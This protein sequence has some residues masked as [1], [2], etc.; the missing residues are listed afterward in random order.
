MCIPAPRRG[1]CRHW[2]IHRPSRSLPTCLTVLWHPRYHAVRKPFQRNKQEPFMDMQ[3]KGKVVLITG[4]SQGIGAGLA[5]AFAEEGCTLI[6]VAR[7]ADKL[8]D[9]A[10]RLKT[11]FQADTR[12][13]AVDLTQRDAINNLVMQAGDIDILINNAGN[14][15]GGNLWEVDPDQ[16]RHGW[17]LKVLGYIDM[18]RAFYARMRERGHGVIL[19]NIGNGGEMFDYDY[20]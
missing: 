4:A 17:E 16:W 3:L 9:L 19:N 8:H 13:L 11:Q 10:D 14:I 7:T 15:P 5:E 6:L 1:I 20:I 18:C 12:V 2:A